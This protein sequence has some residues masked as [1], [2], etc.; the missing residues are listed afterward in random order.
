[1]A[2]RTARRMEFPFVLDA[3]AELEIST[4]LMFG[5]TA[6]YARGQI[7]LAL[8]DKGD[9]PDDGVW[10]ATTHEHHESLRR[11]LPSLRTI[12]ILGPGPT[13]WQNIPADSPTFE[14]EALAACELIVRRDPRIGKTPAKKKPRVTAKGTRKKGG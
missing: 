10:L 2:P 6:L 8:R 11:E 14:Q 4:R 1:M 12:G 5:C 3:L 9:S 13:G 7:V